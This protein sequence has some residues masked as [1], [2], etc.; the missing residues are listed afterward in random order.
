[1]MTMHTTSHAA[2]IFPVGT[3]CKQPNRQ[4]LSTYQHELLLENHVW[5]VRFST[6]TISFGKI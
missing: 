5:L 2:A 4:E 6:L 3:F 1:M